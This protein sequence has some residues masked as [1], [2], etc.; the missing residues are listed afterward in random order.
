MTDLQAKFLATVLPEHGIGYYYGLALGPEKAR[1]QQAFA[2]AG[3]VY[4]F[5]RGYSAARYDTYMALAV[6]ADSAHGRRAINAAGLRCVWADLDVQ[7]T[8]TPSYDSLEDAARALVAFSKETGLNPTYVVQSGKGLHAYWAFSRTLPRDM[9][10]EIATRFNA[11]QVQHGLKVDP[12]CVGDAARVLRMPGTIHTGTGA[13]VQIILDN[14]STPY[15]PE[16]FLSRVGDKLK[17]MPARH[18]SVAAA[19]VPPGAPPAVFTSNTILKAMGMIQPPTAHAEPIVRNCPALLTMGLQSY[20]Q[21]FLGM[22]VLRRCVDGREWAHRLSAL[23]K[24]RYNPTDTDSKFDNAGED[25]PARCDAFRAVCPEVCAKCLYKATVVTPVQL[26]RITAAPQKAEMPHLEGEPDGATGGVRLVQPDSWAFQR[27]P[28]SHPNYIVDQRGIVKLIVVK[29]AQ[30]GTYTTQEVVICTS[31]LYFL[32]SETRIIDDRP[33]RSY[34]FEAVHP[35]GKIEHVRYIIEQDSGPQQAL[36]WFSNANMYGLQGAAG[37]E[38]AAFM[39]AYLASVVHGAVDLPT[40]D[41][42]GWHTYR[43]DAGQQETGFVVGSGLV[44]TRGM[45]P[46]RFG[47]MAAPH[48]AKEFAHAGTLEKWRYIPQMYK[49]LGQEIG[50]LAICMAFAAPLMRYGSGEAKNAVLSIWS[51]TSGQ[52]KSQLLA[53]CATIW[54]NPQHAFFSRQESVVA[55]MRRLALWSNIPALMDELTDVKDEDMYNLAYTLAGGKEKNK[56]RSSGDAFIATGDWSTC[57]L[58]TANRSF[59]E[60]VTRFAGDSEAT[61]LRVMEYECA[62]PSYANEPAVQNYINA[63]MA[64]C[65]ENYGLAGPEFMFQLL[66]RPDRLATLTNLAERWCE[67][68]RLQTKERFMGY[69]LALSLMAGRWAVEWGLLDYDMNALEKWVVEVFIPHNRRHTAAYAPDM[70]ELLAGYISE[71]SNHTLIVRC[72]DRPPEMRDPANELAPD[73]YIIARPSHGEVKMRYA[74]DDHEL[75]ITARDLKRWCRYNRISMLSLIKRLE[76]M[77]FKIRKSKVQLTKD[78][79]SMTGVSQDGFVLD[80]ETLCKLGFGYDAFADTQQVREADAQAL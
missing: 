80:S 49:T 15:S 40:V 58:T 34:M 17:T 35:G 19:S 43:N 75:R 32:Y 53:A 73:Q 78:V 29:D 7:K 10:A 9:W 68:N 37:K 46:V 48:A 65:R 51:P 42:F 69:P 57:T 63:C 30:T 64:L 47:A 77:G 79:R 3:D 26:E 27:M 50:Q 31:Q 39:N 41:K 45:R 61:L 14:S 56:L 66:Q 16:D 4:D 2:C 38:L 67:Q 18:T 5:C 11:L 6:F 76:S 12:A 74:F 36:R 44:T 28:I 8:R 60:A 52:G 1:V 33:Q 54:G 13:T 59:K 25:S 70:R 71:Q 23:D 24:V 22:S 55:R 62:F 72:E 20:Q 21:W